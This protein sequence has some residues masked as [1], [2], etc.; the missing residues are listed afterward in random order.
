M[1]VTWGLENASFVEM[2]ITTI[3][4]YDGVHR[5]HLEILT[6]L[7]ELKKQFGLDRSIVLTFDPH[8]QEI[9]RRNNTNVDLLT[10][11]EERLALLAS[12]GVDEVLVIKFSLDFAKTEYSTFFRRVLIETLGTKAMVVGFNHAFGKNREG[13]ITHL[14]TLASE[15]SISVDA[16]PPLVVDGISVSSTKIRIALIQGDLKTANQYLG[17]PFELNGIVET[18]DRLGQTLGFPT[19]NLRVAENK[20]IPADGVYS[21]FAW[22]A[23]DRHRAAI[24]IGTRQTVTNSTQRKVEVH[25]LD[26]NSNI[27][28]EELKI[29]LLEYLRPQRK[30][31]SLDSLKR[32]MA[33]DILIV[34]SVTN[35]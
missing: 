33:N 22:L 32:Q 35:D 20:L 21:G 11:I 8:P 29:K 27:Y 13:D 24:S 23:G 31:D 1:K 5:G 15:S 17:R 2:T 25:I 4:S 6:R 3:G 14:E 16:V 12:C 10:T 7:F 30:F 19:A 26:F 18:G 9:L 28:E 34:R